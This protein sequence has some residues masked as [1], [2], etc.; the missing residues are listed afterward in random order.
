MKSKGRRE[1]RGTGGED[2]KGCN[3]GGQE[4]KNEEIRKEKH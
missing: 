2:D 1:G 4:I 3:R